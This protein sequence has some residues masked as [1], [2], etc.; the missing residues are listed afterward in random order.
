[1][2]ELGTGEE[3]DIPAAWPFLTPVSL[4][5]ILCACSAGS[6]M[7]ALSISAPVSCQ[8][9]RKKGGRKEEICMLLRL[10]GG[11]GSGRG[12]GQEEDSACHHYPSF[13][14]LLPS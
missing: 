11:Q 1:M 14:L 2:E 6:T 9:F 3:E 7:A 8:L 13:L 12:K 4:S 10:K 5:T